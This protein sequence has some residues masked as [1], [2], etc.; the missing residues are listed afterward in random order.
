MKDRDAVKVVIKHITTAWYGQ[1]R[2]RRSKSLVSKSSNGRGY[3]YVSLKNVSEAH[4][5]YVF[6]AIDRLKQPNMRDTVLWDPVFFATRRPLLEQL[7]NHYG[8]YV[9]LA[10]TKM[11]RDPFRFVATLQY[12]YIRDHWCERLLLKQVHPYAILETRDSIIER[13]ISTGGGQS[14]DQFLAQWYSSEIVALES[15]RK[16]K[17]RVERIKKMKTHHAWLTRHIREKRKRIFAEFR[18][19]QELIEAQI[20]QETGL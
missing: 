5:P 1:C 18:K 12:D 6:I 20:A 9:W 4:C 11:P 8:H 10:V 15:L 16:T 13:G 2:L 3:W 14:T 17:C 19:E 7:M